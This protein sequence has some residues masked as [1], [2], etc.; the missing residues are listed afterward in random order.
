LRD[1][2]LWPE[3]RVDFLRKRLKLGKPLRTLSLWLTEGFS[4]PLD[5][6]AGYCFVVGTLAYPIRIRF[7]HPAA[8]K[9]SVNAE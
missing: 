6:E 3:N 5:V 7:Q 4:M 8:V 9:K 2:A 1:L